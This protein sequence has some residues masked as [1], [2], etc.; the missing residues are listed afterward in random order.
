MKTSNL[1]SLLFLALL[2]VGLGMNAQS[3]L[4]QKV[5][6]SE[7]QSRQLELR[8]SSPQE[9]DLFKLNTPALKNLLAQAPQ[10]FSGNSNVIIT[11]PT[12]NGE[13]QRFRVYEASTFA[14]ELQALHPNT[15]SYAAKGIDD[16]T[17]T[18]RFSISDFGG[19]NVMISSGNYSTIYIDPYTQDKNYYI[20]YNINKLPANEGA[21]CLVESVVGAEMPMDSQR[22]ANDG[23]LRTYRLALACTHQYANYHLGILGIPSTATDAEK[24]AA[25]LSQFNVA[26][27]RVNG[28]YERDASLTM[29]LVPNTDLLICLTA[30]TDPYTNQNVQAMLGQNQTQCDSKIGDANYDIGHVFGTGPG[31]IARLKSPCVSGIK[32]MGATGLPQPIGDN[33]H[34]D[35]VSHEMG[36]QFGANH[37]FNNSCSGNRN[38]GT[39]MEVG[40]G[41]TIMAYAG[42]CPPNVAMHSDDY[43]HAI[44][45]QE[46]WSNIKYGVSSTCPVL[47]DNFNT[48]P[49]ANA[50]GNYTVPKSTPFVLTGTA[51]DADGDALTHSWEQMNP[52]IAPQPPLTT[53]TQGPTFRSLPPKSS[54]SRFFP[55]MNFVL[56]NNMGGNSSNQWEV[57]PSVN[58]VMNFRYT[59]RD[60]SI[61]GGASA[62]SDM[63][64]TT[65]GSAGPFVVT[66]QATT[67]FWDTGTTQTIT[68]DVAGTD[69]APINCSNVDIFFS[70]DSGQ[71]FPITVA[72][73]QPNTGSAVVNVPNLNTIKGRLMVKASDNVFFN[74]N[75]AAI[76]VQ[77]TVGVEDFTFENFSVYPNPSTGTFNLSFT[78]DSAE[79]INVSLYDLRGRLINQVIYNDGST[80]VFNKQLDYNYIDTGMYFLVVKNGNKSVTK[81]LVKK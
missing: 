79:R 24:K 9:F 26:M 44:S 53:S 52:Q 36:H 1:K 21:E 59:V 75:G 48:A 55:S 10:R 12:N 81:K 73:N 66:S 35:F 15:R 37:T 19:V 43:F 40:S 46:I 31:G 16:A 74:V 4:W 22:N 62:S 63:R 64:I 56:T 60:N 41:T 68:W 14:P 51:S 28:I 6:T 39:A 57:V 42:T 29:V 65:V 70:T 71:T 47:T 67:S 32:A 11:L 72:L 33:F 77:G 80:G 27:T 49:T 50:G 76:I 2:T 13:L 61:G 18:A 20:S 54:P 8:N 69:A 23:K 34:I 7:T 58:R 78:P 3:S 45:L 17:A 30:G 5:S 38:A 25:V